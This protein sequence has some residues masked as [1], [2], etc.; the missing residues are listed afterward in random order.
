MNRGKGVGGSVAGAASAGGFGQPDRISGFLASLRA[1]RGFVALSVYAALTAGSLSLA[2]ALRFDFQVPGHHAAVLPLYLILLISARSLAAVALGLPR[3]RWRYVG[4][5]EV[6]RLVA[7][8]AS[9]TIVLLA[10]GI[11]APGLSAVPLSVAVVE[12]ALFTLATAGVWIGYRVAAESAHARRGVQPA[13][14]AR[15]LLVVGSGEAG[16]FLARELNRTAGGYQVVGFL[17]DDP[18][19]VGTHVHGAAV[20]G[21]TD[22]AV[23]VVPGLDV[24]EVAIAIPSA[25]PEELRRIVEALEPLELPL[26]V[27]PG[28]REVVRG[29]RGGAPFRKLRIEDLLGREPV[30]LDLPELVRDLEGRTILV[31]G[32]AGSIGSELARQLAANG[33]RHLILLDQAE[34]DLY[35]VDLELRKAHPELEIVSLIGDVVDRRRMERLFRALSPDRVYHAAAYKHVPLMEANPREAVRNNVLGTWQVAS[36]AAEHGAGR[37]VLVST[38]KAADPANTMGATKRGA[39]LVVQTLQDQYPRTHFS[40]VR[41]GNVLGSNGSVVPLFEQQI[42]DG[43]PITI[44]HEGV[45][46]YFMTIPEAVQLILQA[47][48][49]EEARGRVAMLEMGE[50]VRIVDLARNMVRLKGLRP[51]VDIPFEYIGLRP[52][53]KLHERLCGEDE[54]VE[55]TS[56]A[57]VQCLR[58]PLP[59]GLDH[60]LLSALMRVLGDDRI[61]ARRVLRALLNGSDF[62]L[63]G[64]ATAAERPARAAGGGR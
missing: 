53:E 37:F 55:A 22:D 17:D 52:G 26:S 56:L 46:R 19:K 21:T 7:V 10:V 38:D 32:A 54:A 57:E 33:P 62:R 2:Y 49:L 48:L 3:R 43:G 8:A 60:T 59:P 51:E 29:E 31:T 47:S 25:T 4:V 40:A 27:V 64:T 16:N 23:A 20:L 13:T 12:L 30:S 41:F 5:G 58:S 9:G 14:P 34:S 15:R 45:T 6:L 44:T 28:I 35:F 39:E 11:V 50:P 18:L 1:R 63:A 61:D 36:L 42:E 24:E